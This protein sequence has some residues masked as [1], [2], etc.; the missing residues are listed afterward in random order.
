MAKQA[1]TKCRILYRLTTVHLAYA[2]STG[3]LLFALLLLTMNIDDI[4]S[5]ISLFFIAHARNGRIS[6]S[7]LKSDVTIVFL[8]PISFK[9]REFRRFGHK[10]K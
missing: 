6:I 10:N 5:K 8:D 9:T 2:R 3:T 4:G 7:G 1:I